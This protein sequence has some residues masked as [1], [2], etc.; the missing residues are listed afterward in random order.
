MWFRISRRSKSVTSG[1][2][3][4]RQATLCHSFSSITLRLKISGSVMLPARLEK[5]ILADSQAATNAVEPTIRK[6]LA[7]LCCGYND[8]RLGKCVRAL[9]LMAAGAPP[10][11]GLECSAA[12]GRPQGRTRENRPG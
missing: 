7:Y 1:S 4:R 10:R 9:G 8:Q 12:Y 11:F 2:A 6:F 5:Q 3:T